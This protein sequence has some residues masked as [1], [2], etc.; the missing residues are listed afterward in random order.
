MARPHTEHPLEGRSLRHRRQATLQQATA[1]KPPP[2]GNF[3]GYDQEAAQAAAYAAA[4]AEGQ[5]RKGFVRKVF[6]LV[7]LQLCVTIGVASCFIFVDAVR[8]YVRPGGDG[9]WVFIVSWI[10]SL[11]MMIA[12]M[13]SKTLR[14]KHPWNLLALVVFTLVMS[15]LVGTICAYWQTSVVLEAFAVTG[16]AVAGLTLVAVFGKFD[17]TKK[18]HILAMAGGV[19]FM[20][21]LV[22][23]LVGFFYV[24]DIQMVMGG[25]AYAISPDEYVFASVQIYM[26]VIIIFLQASHE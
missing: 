4:F 1:P 23:M 21:L 14:R 13:C 7:F 12:I 10:T 5:V 2:Q 11:V 25:K 9:Q 18:G 8:E 19:T 24:Y 22:T 15:V 16:A 20:V 17:I 26:D 3:D 6:L